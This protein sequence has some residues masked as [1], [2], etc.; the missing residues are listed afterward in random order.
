M[1]VFSVTLLT[2]SLLISEDFRVFLSFPS[3][4]SIFS[5][6]ARGYK[7]TAVAEKREEIPEIL[8]N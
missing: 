2:F 5:T 6:F 1:D 3:G 7:N 8:T 4:R